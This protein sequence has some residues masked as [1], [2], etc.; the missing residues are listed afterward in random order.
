MDRRDWQDLDRLL[1]QIWASYSIR[2]WIMYETGK[3][4]RDQKDHAP[5]L[6]PELTRRGFVDL[7]EVPRLYKTLSIR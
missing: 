1:V 4:G 2:P 5:S 7:V 6:L 3:E